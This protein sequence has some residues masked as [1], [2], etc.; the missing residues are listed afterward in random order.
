MK[1]LIFNILLALMFVGTIVFINYGIESMIKDLANDCR[2]YDQ[3]NHYTILSD[4]IIRR[5]CDGHCF[6][7]T[8]KMWIDCP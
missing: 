6:T 1:D 7:R 4:E 2:L 8:Q 5:D 3:D